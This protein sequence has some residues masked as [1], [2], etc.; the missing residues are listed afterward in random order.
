MREPYRRHAQDT[1]EPLWQCSDLGWSAVC[2]AIALSRYHPGN[3]AIRKQW[4]HEDRQPPASRGSTA[5][6]AMPS[7]PAAPGRR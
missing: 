7:I 2:N 3:T 5:T 4:R 6:T 1:D